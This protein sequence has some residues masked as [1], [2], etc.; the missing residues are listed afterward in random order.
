MTIDWRSSKMAE[1]CSINFIYLFFTL[2]LCAIAETHVKDFK[3]RKAA[4]K[5]SKYFILK[6]EKSIILSK[7]KCLKRLLY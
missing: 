5:I 3:E 2:L 6:Q 1:H 7:M 4:Y